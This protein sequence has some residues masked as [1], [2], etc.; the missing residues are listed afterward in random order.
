MGLEASKFA[1]TRARSS[2]PT[3]RRVA[4]AVSLALAALLAAPLAAQEK[5]ILKA[6]DVHPLGYPTV[7]AVENLG[8]KCIS[9]GFNELYGALQTGVVDG[10]ENN[11]PSYFTQNHFNF[12]KYYSLTEHL[13]IPEILVFS[14]VAW[15]KLSKSDQD[16]IRKLAREAQAKQRALW[17]QR[18]AADTAKLKAAGVTFVEVDKKPFYAATQAVRDKYGAPYVQLIQRIEAVR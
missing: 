13:I 6:A 5:M 18:V 16:V 15:N 14:K 4:L 12:A 3:S 10:A 11:A 17:D 1:M 7:Q 8:K 2:A 9:L